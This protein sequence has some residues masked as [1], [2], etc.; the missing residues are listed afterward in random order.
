M[1]RRLFI[2]GLIFLLLSCFASFAQEERLDTLQASVVTG[3]RRVRFQPGEILSSPGAIK[4]A[5]SPLGE[6][7]PIRWIQNL[8]GVSSGADGMSASFVRGSNIGG[9]LISLDGVPVYGYSHILGLTMVVPTDVI[10]SVSFA[11]GGFGGNQGNLSASHIAISTKRPATDT[12]RTT[13]FI[14]NFL[15]GGQHSGPISD[16]MSYLVSGRI[17][18]LALE[19]SA[20]KGMM[21]GHLGSL[22]HFKAGVGDLYG[23]F[24]WDIGNGKW[25]TASILG[26]LDL[27]GFNMPDGT[28]NGMGWRNLIGSVQYHKPGRKG[29]SIFSV[30][31]NSY[32]SS[33]E[34]SNVYNGTDNH[35][36]LRSILDEITISNDYERYS[37]SRRKWKMGARLRYALFRPGDIAGPLNRKHTFMATAYLQ[38]LH[39]SGK[40][41]WEW[42]LRPTAFRSDKTMFSVDISMKGKW[43]F[44]PFLA[45]EATADAMSQ[46]Y[47]TLEGLP[48]G[49]SMDLLVPSVSKVPAEQML[50]GYA[51]L[52]ASFGRHMVSAG[53]YIKELNNIIY[54]KEAHNFFN[55]GISSWE[56]DVELGKGDS[57]GIEMMYQYQGDDLQVQASA[58]VSKSTRKGFSQVNDGKPFHAPFD[59]R[60]VSNL[61]VQWKA[62]NLNFTWQ[63]GNW[64]NGAGERYTVIDPQGK[65]VILEYFS[66]INN[67]QMPALI[68]L[69]IG[70]RRQWR[71]D[72]FDHELSLGVF[73][74]LNHFNPFTV[75]YDTKDETWKE[76]ALIPIMPNISYRI[77]F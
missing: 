6:G 51:G 50:Q 1:V 2:T 7:D 21:G 48:I 58:T 72:R 59:R 4:A 57:K 40:L 68:R 44:L 3:V 5:A 55:S 19:Y 34:L 54:Y 38:A 60:L 67:Y 74:V 43:Q 56:S 46:Y 39:N 12:S 11:K 41:N 22:D 31:Y 16:N 75:Y 53:A 62:F 63:D 47:H 69:D 64:V 18:P 65:E 9:N 66:S 15:A 36:Y 8:P 20:L 70:Y 26:S 17:S 33:Q 29:E 35:Y 14:N 61:S 45:L 30:S 25:L 42:T 76:L 13:L 27:Y 28:D 37:E 10:E 73:N 24:L 77:S 52:E 32:V 49:W 23:K 71:K